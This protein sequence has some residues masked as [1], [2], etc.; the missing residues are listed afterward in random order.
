MGYE[1]ASTVTRP[2]ELSRRGGILDIFPSTAG[3]PVRMELFGDVI[4]SIR[5]AAK[6]EAKI[7]G[8]ARALDVTPHDDLKAPR[9]VE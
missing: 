2:G 4:E 3:A 9:G 6:G 7:T 1:A 5:L 8:R